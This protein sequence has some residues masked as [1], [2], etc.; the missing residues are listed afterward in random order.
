MLKITTNHNHAVRV[1]SYT[2]GQNFPEIEGKLISVEL[3]GNEL[4]KYLETKEIPV[5]E[6]MHIT[7]HDKHAG[8]V[9]K[10]LREIL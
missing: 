3:S 8:R 5:Q 2:I 9:L 1:Y 6:T 7:W 10:E 4:K